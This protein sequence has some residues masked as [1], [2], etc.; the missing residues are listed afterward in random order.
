MLTPEPIS[1]RAAVSAF[2]HCSVSALFLAAWLILVEAGTEVWYRSHER[3]AV[4]GVEWSV[5]RPAQG[6][7]YH[8][9]EM[10]ASIRGQFN[11]DEGT[12]VR[13]RG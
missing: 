10:P 6:S 8:E 12:Q 11:A 3:A 4:G 9:V 2:Q 1:N 5:R 13:W 7:S